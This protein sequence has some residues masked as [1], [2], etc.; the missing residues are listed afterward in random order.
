MS[1]AKDVKFGL[2]GMRKNLGFTVVAV[3]TLALAIGANSAIFSIIDAVLLRPLPYDHPDRIVWVWEATDTFIGSA[4]WPNFMDWRQQNTTFETLSGWTRRNVTLQQA[5]APERV[6]AAVVTADFFQTL[7]VQPILGRTFAK[8]EDA[9]G[10]QKTVVLSAGLWK[11]H[12]GSDPN[13]AGRA[14][15]IGGEPHVVLGVLPEWMNFPAN[16]QV[17]VPLIPTEDQVSTRGNHFMLALGRLKP[18]VTLGQAQQEMKVIAS[19][20]AQQYP[21]NQAKRS[22]RLVNLQEQLVGTSRPTLIALLAAVGFVLLIACAN[23]ANLLLARVTGRRREIAIRIALGAGKGQL[24]RQFLTESVLLAVISGLVGLAI[25]KISMASL[26]AWAAPF[27][28]RATEVSLD[29]RVVVFSMVA[30]ALTGVLCGVVPAIQSWKE[31]PQNS[32]K[33]GGTSAGSAQANWVTGALAVSEVAASVV[34]LIAAGLM[35]RSVVKLQDTNPGFEP[36]NVIT[37]KI[38][39]PPSSYNEQ[40]AP[41]FYDEVLRRVSALPGVQYAGAITFLPAEQWGWNGDLTV[42]GVP[43]FDNLTQGIERRYVSENYFRAM[44]IPLVKGR[45]FN[46]GDTVG[47]GSAMLINQTLAKMIEPYGDPVGK[48]VAGD[49]EGQH[50]T[51]VGVVGDVKQAGLNVPPRPEMYVPYETPVMAGTIYDLSLVI[52][53]TGDPTGIVNGVRREVAAVDANQAVYGVKSMQ[54]IVEDSFT[55]FSFTRTLVSVFAVLGTLLA[56]IGVYSVLSYLVSQHTR[57]IG[58]RMALGAQKT[59]ITK[60]VLNQAVLV[61]VLGVAIGVGGAFG[62]T[63]LLASMLYGVKAYDPATFA[64]ASALLFAVVLVACYVP[65]WRA[66]RVDPMVVL[67]HD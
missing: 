33:Q 29:W 49:D 52:R 54:E 7:G 27:L 30:A 21:E 3:L 2:R 58:I 42:E 35:I 55:N 11:T 50:L 28:P 26:V 45:F 16:V 59:D 14:I 37:M 24:V 9:R 5:Q 17:W 8:G 23:V 57:E 63:R 22:I 41:R 51:I 18:G 39:L 62:L 44:N 38:A 60:M 46:N 32:L 12:F 40:T 19:R 65:A 1:L 56:V 4:S 61:G 15:T 53:A 66:T 31:D 36:T 47:K 43:P 10:S 6:A 20:L 34:L 48:L 67:R 13:I 64:S 25:A